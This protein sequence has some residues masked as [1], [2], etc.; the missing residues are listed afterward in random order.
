MRT[1]FWLLASVAAVPVAGAVYQKL[2]ERS[3]RRRH[4][5]TGVLI[6]VGSSKIYVYD[7]GPSRKDSTAFVDELVLGLE[8]RGFTPILEEGLRHAQ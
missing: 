1:L 7:V 6:R 2:S 4:Q 3:D 5:K 8:D